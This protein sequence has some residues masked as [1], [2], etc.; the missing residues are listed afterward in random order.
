[1]MRVRRSFSG[2]TPATSTPSK[3]WTFFI[4]PILL[5]P[6]TPEIDNN[7]PSSVTAAFRD[8][9][10]FC[11]SLDTSTVD[12]GFDLFLTPLEGRFLV[13]VSSSRG[14]DI[15]RANSD[16]FEE[17]TP[18]DTR[19]YLKYLKKR[20]AAF[21]LKMDTEDLPFILELKK[22]DPFGTSSGRSA[23]A[24]DRAQWSARP[25]HV[26]MSSTRFKKTACRVE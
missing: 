8:E 10:C 20:K 18:E 14:D 19:E 26:S 2:H 1:M 21:T 15:V 4:S 12:D 5:T 7:S 17:S 24:V 25:A 6:T 13:A 16:M 22:D 9:S 11:D 23:S 3:S